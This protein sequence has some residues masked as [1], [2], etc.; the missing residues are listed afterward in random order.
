MKKTI[1]KQV[2]LFLFI[3]LSVVDI[4]AVYTK[5]SQVITVVKP[6]LMLVLLWYFLANS[7][8]RN[9]L[10]ILALIFSFFGDVFLLST[11]KLFFLSGL[12]SFL[13]AHIF[14]ILL[15]K[16]RLQKPRGIQLLIAVI[17]NLIILVFLLRF[18]YPSLGEMKIPVTIYGSTITTFGAV[19]LLYF[20]QKKSKGA[21]LLVLGT[22]AFIVSDAV[23]AI[24]LFYKPFALFP[25]IIMVTY[26][27]AQFLICKFVLNLEN[28]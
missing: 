8:Y 16:A 19:S 22:Y 15:V 7:L 13:I 27:L 9:K 6:F 3:L 28:V 14:Y 17:P 10:Y 26:L 21:L 2:P 24:N 18:L 12:I 1:H 25:V 5:N 11:E 20:L 4:W 23:L